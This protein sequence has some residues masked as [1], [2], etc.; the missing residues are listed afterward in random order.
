MP[1][2]WWSQLI[3][4]SAIAIGSFL[5]SWIFTNLLRFS[6][7]AYVAVMA[8]VTGAFLLGA[9]FQRIEVPIHQEKRGSAGTNMVPAH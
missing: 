2:T 7:T 3:W 1:I 8:V 6:R 9:V 5:L 4:L